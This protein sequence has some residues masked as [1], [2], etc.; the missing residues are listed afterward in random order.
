MLAQHWLRVPA[1]H[2][3]KRVAP[4]TAIPCTRRLPMPH[5]PSSQ[6]GARN[7]VPWEGN[8]QSSARTTPMQRCSTD[9][10]KTYVTI[11]PLFGER[12]RAGRLLGMHSQASSQS[13]EKHSRPAPVPAP[14]LALVGDILSGRV[15]CVSLLLQ[16]YASSQRQHIKVTPPH[17]MPAAPCHRPAAVT[18]DSQMTEAMER[19][20]TRAVLQRRA[21][22]LQNAV[23]CAMHACRAMDAR[24]RLPVNDADLPAVASEQTVDQ[25]DT[26]STEHSCESTT[27]TN[28]QLLYPCEHSTMY[29]YWL[30]QTIRDSLLCILELWHHIDEYTRSSAP[31]AD[32]SMY[33][34]A[35]RNCAGIQ[36]LTH[37]MRPWATDCHARATINQQIHKMEQ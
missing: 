26:R 29:T 5:T 21:S 16:P 36:R 14:Q 31:D 15:S 12:A 24:D 10:A 23:Q 6:S 1:L 37:R 27:G 8:G 4:A 30:R 35:M 19:K 18:R 28:S 2:Q 3:S 9:T 13:T 11:T 32:G 33:A 34:A 25:R 22:E 17:C 7:T 20:H